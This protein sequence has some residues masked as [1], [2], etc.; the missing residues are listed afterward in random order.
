[1]RNQVKSRGSAGSK[2]E[3]QGSDS[4]KRQDVRRIRRNQLGMM[5]SHMESRGLV[6]GPVE[7]MMRVRWN[8]G[9]SGRMKKN[10]EGPRGIKRD[11]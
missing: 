10:D 9:E 1:M 6:K 11:E 8:Q 2:R 5:W 7:S 4:C 3:Q